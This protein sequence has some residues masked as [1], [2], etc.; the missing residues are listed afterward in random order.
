MVG[1]TGWVETCVV[2]VAVVMVD[3]HG[4]IPLSTLSSLVG[5]WADKR[6]EEELQDLSVGDIAAL[7]ERW[8]HV[9][10]L[11]VVVVSVEVGKFS[12]VA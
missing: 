9:V 10:P 6:L 3:P 12:E 2:P 7:C 1:T 11:L 4:N 5:E 8:D